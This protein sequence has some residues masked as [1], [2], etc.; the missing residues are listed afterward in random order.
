[1]KRTVQTQSLAEL[2]GQYLTA[3]ILLCEVRELADVCL[4]G[5]VP[6]A[7]QARV[8][9]AG[10]RRWLAVNAIYAWLDINSPRGSDWRV[11]VSSHWVCTQLSEEEAR[12]EMPASLPPPRRQRKAGL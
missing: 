11:G 5:E 9:A 6:R 1:M 12:S 2:Q 10:R 4:R 3:D 8:E 7:L